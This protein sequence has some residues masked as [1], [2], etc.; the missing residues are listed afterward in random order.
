MVVSNF[1][2]YMYIVT[3]GVI[4]YI[5]TYSNL[6]VKL[7]RTPWEFSKEKAIHYMDS[8][9]TKEDRNLSRTL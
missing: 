1:D 9:L 6:T 4:K 3:E 7:Q 2:I 5:E 8:D